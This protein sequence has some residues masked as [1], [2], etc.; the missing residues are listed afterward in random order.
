MF[1]E[2]VLLSERDRWQP[3]DCSAAVIFKDQSLALTCA[4][5]NIAAG[6]VRIRAAATVDLP[7]EFDLE[8]SAYPCG[9]NRVLYGALARPMA[10][11]S[12]D[13]HTGAA[14][15]RDDLRMAEYTN[16]SNQGPQIS[17]RVQYVFPRDSCAFA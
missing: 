5:E 1:I 4:V 16:F 3:L 7:P 6:A 17:Y 9:L 15:A 10:L 12:P 8:I 11:C 13:H 14:G 2:S